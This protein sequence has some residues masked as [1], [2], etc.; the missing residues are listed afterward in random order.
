MTS[1]MAVEVRE[2]PAAVARLIDHGA[3]AIR[4]TADAARMFDP[5]L[6]TTVATP[7]AATPANNASPVAAT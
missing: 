2:I 5:V 1:Q 6:I 3:P 4:A 7:H